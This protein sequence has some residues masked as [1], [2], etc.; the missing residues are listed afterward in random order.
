MIIDVALVLLALPTLLASGYLFLLASLSHRSGP[1]P[2]PAGRLRFVV[3]V[4]AHDEELGIERTV[5]SLQALD[6]PADRFRV[7]VVADNCSDRTAERAAAAGAEV[8]V[9]AE[10]TRRGKGYALRHAF[11]RILERDGTDAVVVIDADA[12][13]SPNLLAAFA[14]RLEAGARAV[15]A[16]S[17]VLN[18]DDSWRTRLMA[19]ALTLVGD[20]RALGR[21]RLRVSCGLRGIGMCLSV[22]A[23]RSVPYQA[24]SIVEDAE[25]C[26]SLAR[27]GIRVHFAG[28][29]RVSSEMV[30]SGAAA[31]SQR[32]RWEEGRRALARSEALALLRDGLERRDRVLLDLGVDL[33][34]PPLARVSAYAAAGSLAASAL[35]GMGSAGAIVLAPWL[36]CC[37]F[38]AAY[39]ARGVQLSGLGLRGVAAL[40]WAPI[41]MVWK[42]RLLAKPSRSGAREWVRTARVEEGVVTPA[43]GLPAADS[44]R[45]SATPTGT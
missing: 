14:A 4:P 23:L 38:L 18:P 36:L 13:V 30:S 16:S 9:R 37:A 25:Y 19:I 22:G 21:E 34:V 11:E 33:L 32:L 12:V 26:V 35:A 40:A 5:R 8:L 27:A 6:W 1:A 28:E 15:Q 43:E 24:F 10:P 20:V 31:R 7:V 44:E 42:M 29:G 2:R 41:F 45:T 17:G 39:V 3:V